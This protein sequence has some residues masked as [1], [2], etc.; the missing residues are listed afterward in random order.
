MKRR[1]ARRRDSAF[2]LAVACGF[3]LL[4][5]MSAGALADQAERTSAKSPAEKGGD[6]AAG[7]KP[8]LRHVK[9][10]DLVHF[11]HTDYGFTD[12]PAVCRELQKRF[13]D[14]A[15]D[16]VLATRDRP[17][18]ARFCWTAE[19]TVAVGDWWQS[20]DAGRR[21]DFLAALASGQ[22]EVSAL[23]LNNTPFLDRQQWQTMLHWLPEDLWQKVRPQVAIQN[24]V[25]GFP[26][27]GAIALLDRGVRYL[28]TGIN[29][30]SGGPPF[31]RPSAFWWKMPDGRRLL[32]Y[33]NYS[34]PA[35]YWFF[36]TAEWR[37]GPVP[38]AGDTRYRPP[39][40]GDFL[41]ADEASVRKAHRHL[42]ERVRGLEAGGFSYPTLTLSITNQWR[43]DNDPPLLFLADFVAAWSRLGLQP[44]LRLTTASAAMKRLEEEIGP[45]IPL[46]E[47]EW[48]DWWA[49]G[50]GSA[51]REV[52]ASRAAK[53]WIAAAQSPLWGE[54][55][56]NGR[57]A[58]DEMLKDLCLF[59]EHTWGSSNSVALP[60]SLDAQGQFS[61][62][63]A[64]AYRPM[65]R[66]EWLLAQRVRTRLAREAEGLYV[67]NS[68]PVAWSGWI[69]MPV[70]AL[71]EDYR[72]VEDPRSPGASRIYFEPGLR[73]FSP[74]RNPGELSPENTA[75]TFPD[76]AVR[77]VAKFWM[78]KLDG[79]AIRRLRLSTQDP[80]SEP[81]RG[82]AESGPAIQADAAGWPTAITWPGMPKPLFLAGLGDFS[83]VTVK[84]FAPRWV[85]REIW[86]TPDDRREG[87]RKEKLEEIAATAEAK[88]AVD[89]N[90]HTLVYVQAI[91]HPRLAWASRQLEVW[92]REP[93]A[94][95]TLRLNRTSSEAPEVFY[96]AFGLPCQG[97]MPQTSCGGEPFVPFQD[98]L[99]GTCRDYFAIDGWVHYR[100]PQGSWLWVSRDAPLVTFG[101]SQV[102]ARRRDPPRDVHRVLAMVFNNFWYTN[103]VGDSHGVMEFQFDLCW[104]DKLQAADAPALAETLLSEPQVLINPALQEDPIFVHR[105][106]EP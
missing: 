15:V 9:Q 42:L 61:E 49:N 67:A 60:Y 75:A 78:E 14:V 3:G 57:R 32:V 10:I 29:D 73:P 106:Y 58:I 51:P 4:A 59:D 47:G 8:G 46:Y 72:R 104:R 102:L 100:T 74:P 50:T 27:A 23:P 65:A 68:S 7:A 64:F 105:L 30:D 20:A 28:L 70:T 81:P 22:L 37:R 76:R 41:A 33:L 13:L 52:A 80:G 36:E 94:R 5:P 48:T 71:R 45:R 21:S 26:R 54:L 89:D 25:N 66:A 103:F 87:L 55:G 11:S 56:P 16:G 34:Y 69:R 18:S 17:P 85:A 40:P 88:A 86:T 98:Q 90:P 12:H 96:V 63:A 43:I 35:G 79:R 93:R 19:T 101:G 77:Q 44:S 95:L 38:R 84:G 2:C 24:D 53:R 1:A 6:R 39:R 99:P 97:T 92:K 91:R 82:P 83:S 31:P 62:K